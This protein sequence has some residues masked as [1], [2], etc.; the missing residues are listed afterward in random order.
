MSRCNRPIHSK[1]VKAR[2][3]DMNEEG[4]A[5]DPVELLFIFS[6]FISRS[7]LLGPIINLCDRA[8]NQGCIFILSALLCISTWT[9]LVSPL[10]IVWSFFGASNL[11]LSCEFQIYVDCRTP[12][13]CLQLIT[14]PSS[15]KLLLP[16]K[17]QNF[18]SQICDYGAVPYCKATHTVI[19]HIR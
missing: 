5:Q 6:A 2:N 3:G 9:N 19:S 18:K 1:G 11:K 12:I 17:T 13:P 15:R 4:T 8:Q 7:M 14:P 16:H 10:Q